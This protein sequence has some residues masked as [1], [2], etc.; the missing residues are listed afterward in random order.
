MLYHCIPSYTPF[1]CI[2]FIRCILGLYYT[3]HICII[4]FRCIILY[5]LYNTFILCIIPELYPFIFCSYS[6]PLLY[7]TFLFAVYSYILG[8]YYTIRI[9]IISLSFVAVQYISSC[10]YYIICCVIP[11]LYHIPCTFLFL[12]YFSF[13]ESRNGSSSTLTCQLKFF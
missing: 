12:F 7:C 4:S 13:N 9:C 1:R 8:L 10:L 2:L 11:E 3:I 6:I 5:S